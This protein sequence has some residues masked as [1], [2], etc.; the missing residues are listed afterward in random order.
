MSINIS[1]WVNPSSSKHASLQLG[2][3][4]I[5]S[6]T[7]PPQKRQ[8]RN[9]MR[10]LAALCTLQGMYALKQ[11]TSLKCWGLGT[12]TARG[13]KKCCSTLRKLKHFSGFCDISFDIDTNQEIA[14]CFL[15]VAVRKAPRRS[16]VSPTTVSAPARELS[17]RDQIVNSNSETSKIL[18]GAVISVHCSH[19]W[20]I[21]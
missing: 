20:Y 10:G 2:T 5:S 6:L 11:E 7:T 19:Q 4:Y 21:T 17:F 12:S 15:H 8:L 9:G 18:N 3:F 14:R 1:K 13:D 16:L